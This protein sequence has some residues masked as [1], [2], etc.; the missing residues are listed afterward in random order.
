MTS[1]MNIARL[2]TRNSRVLAQI[3]QTEVVSTTSKERK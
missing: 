1:L 3:V 2:R